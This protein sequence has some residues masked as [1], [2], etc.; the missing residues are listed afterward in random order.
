VCRPGVSAK[1]AAFNNVMTKIVH[2]ADGALPPT[3][4]G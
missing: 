2:E 1:W 3:C 4:F